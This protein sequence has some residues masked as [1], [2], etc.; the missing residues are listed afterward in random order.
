[1]LIDRSDCLYRKTCEFHLV[2]KNQKARLST[3]HL[4]SRFHSRLFS[5]NSDVHSEW[6]LYATDCFQKR[7][8]VAKDTISRPLKLEARKQSTVL[9]SI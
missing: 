4:F 2:S 8:S 3:G 6:P 7:L 9:I 1:M 5:F